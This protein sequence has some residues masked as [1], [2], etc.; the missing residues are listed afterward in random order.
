MKKLM[1]I[2][3][4]LLV[5]MFMFIQIPMAWAVPPPPDPTPIDGGLGIL[6]AAGIAYGARKLYKR[7]NA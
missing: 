3:S 5:L 7:K 6:A 2:S 4:V 1:I